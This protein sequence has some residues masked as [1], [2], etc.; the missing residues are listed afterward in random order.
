MDQTVDRYQKIK[1]AFNAI[2]HAPESQRRELLETCCGGDLELKEGVRS[3]LDTWAVEEQLNMSFR[4]QQ[5]D[6]V[7]V[8]PQ[9]R[10]VGPYQID[11]LLGRGGMGSVYLAHRA[12]GQFEQSVAIK[13]ID[14]PIGSHLFSERL[15]QERQILAGLQH[16]Y[17]ARL[18]N[19]G[20]A[21]DGCP[22]I[23]MEYVEGLPIQRFSTEHSLTEVE[24][25]ELFL[26]VCEAVQFAHQ[27]FV[28]HRDL[29]PDNILVA[30]DGTPHSA[31][32]CRPSAPAALQTEAS[33]PH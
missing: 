27:N 28:V 31:L 30:A 21:E 2:V 3:M 13:L 11:R 4:S 6:G 20:V 22:Y 26:R 19:G 32:D 7:A 12:D 14:L 24:R 9:Q 25:I 5:G 16:P 15:R 18:L 23:A 33:R 10:R 17:I 1:S 8:Q 29:K